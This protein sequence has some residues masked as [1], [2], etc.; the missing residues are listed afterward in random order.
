MARRLVKHPDRGP[1]F[2]KAVLGP[3]ISRNI[4]WNTLEFI[5]TGFVH[6]NLRN[7]TCDIL[8]QATWIGEGG[9]FKVALLPEFKSTHDPRT[10]LQMVGY[11]VRYWE[12]YAGSSPEKLQALPDVLPIVVHT[13]KTPWIN[14]RPLN[15]VIAGGRVFSPYGIFGDYLKVDFP[16]DDFDR[17]DWGEG[18]LRAGALALRNSGH[19]FEDPMKELVEI[20]KYVEPGSDLVTPLAHYFCLAYDDVTD[21]MAG[22]SFA[23]VGNQQGVDA[24]AYVADVLEARGMAKGMAKGKAESLLQVLDARF[25]P[26]PDSEEKRVYAADKSDLDRLIG[27]AVVVP[28]PDA[29]FDGDAETDVLALSTPIEMGPTP[30]V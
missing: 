15:G 9:P 12:E 7:S 10:A 27:K 20:A 26:V 19:K 8:A 22:E 28:S 2:F 14:F 24:V 30:T 17:I 5:D 21:E 13:G 1:Q 18:D 11:A 3:E 23:K 16:T 6:E 4:D 29:L 25:G